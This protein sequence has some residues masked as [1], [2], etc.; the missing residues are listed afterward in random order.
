[1]KI[2]LKNVVKNGKKN[3]GAFIDIY[4]IGALIN[5]YIPGVSKKNRGL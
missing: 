3:N 4:S 1:M 5:R 2:N